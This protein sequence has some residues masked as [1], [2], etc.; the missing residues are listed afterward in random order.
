MQES[1]KEEQ[2]KP[3]AIT[4]VNNKNMSKINEI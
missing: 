1:R 3:Q 4:E 2:N